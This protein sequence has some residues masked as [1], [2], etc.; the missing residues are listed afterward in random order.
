MAKYRLVKDSGTPCKG[1]VACDRIAV[2]LVGG[3]P[4]CDFHSPYD[5]KES[6][7]QYRRWLATTRTTSS[8]RR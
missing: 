6:K 3:R 2:H 1:G 7:A 4:L 8:E 5:T